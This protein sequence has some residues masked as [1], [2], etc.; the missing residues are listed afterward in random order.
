MCVCVFAC[1]HDNSKSVDF[2]DLHEILDPFE[3]I[4][5]ACPVTTGGTRS[6]GG[7]IFTSVT[8]KWE[9]EICTD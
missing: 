3:G 4:N 7:A 5:F 8:Y 6:G 2:K 1:T 9:G